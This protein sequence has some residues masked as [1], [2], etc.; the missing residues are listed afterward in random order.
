MRRSKNIFYWYKFDKKKNAYEWNVL[1]SYL[2]LFFILIGVFFCVTNNIVAA[3]V[4]FLVFGIFYFVYVKEN[5]NFILL[6]SDKN[7]LIKVT[8]HKY[9]V[10]HPMTIYV[11]RG[12]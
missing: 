12:A 11:K 2:R 7:N 5:H 9:S 6:I 1:A 8:G 4:D 10:Y 3:I